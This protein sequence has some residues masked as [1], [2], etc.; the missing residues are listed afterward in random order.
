MTSID[1]AL[2]QAI[3]RLSQ[4]ADTDPRLEAEILLS[5]LLQ[6]PRT[7]I[8]AWPERILSAQQ[9]TKFQELVARRLRG[10]PIAYIIASREFWSLQLTV[11]PETLIPRPETELL[12]ERALELI[13][14]DAEW[15][16]ADLGSGSGAIAAA[17]AVER[18]RCRITASDRSAESLKVAQTNFSTLGLRNV[19]TVL[20]LWFRP[21]A[22]S[23]PFH[24]I[25]SN[26]PYVADDDPYLSK[27]DLPWEP[28][29]ALCSGPDGLDDIRRIISGAPAHLR[30]GGQLLLEHGMDQGRQVRKLLREAGFE[31]VRTHQDLAGLDRMSEGQLGQEAGD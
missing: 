9:W 20:G 12:V 28:Q 1:Q 13:P 26:P 24:L 10:E 27:G 5:F 17:I 19:H 8:I 4:L 30:P 25:V 23:P 14:R 6:K 31:Q 16:I 21:L 11:T 22:G 3:S 7:H 18:P 29:H 15:N 2:Q